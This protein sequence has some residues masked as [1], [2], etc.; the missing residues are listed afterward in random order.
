MPTGVEATAVGFETMFRHQGW[1]SQ[2]RNGV[3]GYQH[4]HSS[5]HEVLGFASGSACLILGGLGGIET[6]VNAGD[7]VL[8]PAGTGYCRLQ[9]SADLLVVGAYPPG[10]DS[11]ICR[12]APSQAML[13]RI[14]SLDVPG[15]D[16][17]TGSE[18]PWQAGSFVKWSRRV[19][20]KELWHLRAARCEEPGRKSS[21]TNRL[22]IRI[23]LSMELG[24]F[25]AQGLL[26]ATSI[27]DSTRVLFSEVSLI[28]HG[29]GV[30]S[31]DEIIA[32]SSQSAEVAPHLAKLFPL[33][34][35]A[36]DTIDRHM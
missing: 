1:P 5:A 3:Y 4:Y 26:T 11:G 15:S 33:I 25:T 8:L 10:Q 21:Q 23:M 16:P 32:K 29:D 34:E 27:R 20:V 9:A 36:F 19:A 30:E 7:A 31:H 2:W 22:S 35:C 14:A 24:P 12:S 18:G 17:I 13:I 6:T 28:M